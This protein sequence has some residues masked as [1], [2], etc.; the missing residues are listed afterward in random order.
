MTVIGRVEAHLGDIDRDVLIGI[1][2][3][4]VSVHTEGFP[5]FRKRS[6]CDAIYEVS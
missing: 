2:A 3:S 1:S 6:L 5:L 4:I